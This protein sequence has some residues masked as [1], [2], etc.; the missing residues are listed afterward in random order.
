MGI[1]SADFP[2]LTHLQRKTLQMLSEGMSNHEIS[3]RN[4]VSEKAVEQ[5]VS[6]I[7]NTLNIMPHHSHNVRVLLT[8]AFIT[9]LKELKK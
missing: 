9:G 8:L 2:L 1:Y 6:R 7:A 5:V 3:L 4:H